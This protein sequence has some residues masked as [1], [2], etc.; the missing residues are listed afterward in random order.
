VSTRSPV[1]SRTVDP[2]PALAGLAPRPIDHPDAAHVRALNYVSVTA[3]RI[4]TF[5]PGLYAL[6]ASGAAFIASFEGVYLNL[7]NDPVGHATIGIGHL[8]HYGPING[9]EPEEFKR[10]LTLDQAY[11]L[12]RTDMG[13][14][15]K[16]VSSL[17]RVELTQNQADA[18]G[19]FT[20]NV[21][22]GALGSSTLLRRLNAGDYAGVPV[23]LM[24]WTKASG[25]ELAGLVRRRRAEG[26]LFAEVGGPPVPVG[27]R[28]REDDE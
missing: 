16:A 21:G 22:E 15:M 14:Y 9:S 19:S 7:Y 27:A 20:M 6:S 26:A 17:V 4:F 18:L 25:K 2:V 8:V 3:R 10:G 12:L 13:R 28:R 23:E 11:D 1:D 24:K 5:A